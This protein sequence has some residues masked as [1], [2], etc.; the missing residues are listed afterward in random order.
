MDAHEANRELFHQLLRAAGVWTAAERIRRPAST[1][2]S[3]RCAGHNFGGLV[4]P[5]SAVITEKADDATAAVVLRPPRATTGSRSAAA[6]SAGPTSAP[7]RA[8]S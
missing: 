1:I 6:T 7:A 2:S 5:E 8:S 4:I 3:W